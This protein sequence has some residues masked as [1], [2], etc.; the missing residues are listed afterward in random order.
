MRTESC[1]KDN[2]LRH[3]RK[4]DNIAL[5]PGGFEEATLFKHGAYRI[6]LKDR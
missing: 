5:L 1:N 2:M 6:F 3:M 4:G